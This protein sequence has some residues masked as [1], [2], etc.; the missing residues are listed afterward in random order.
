MR[1]RRVIRTLLVCVLLGAGAT[2]LSSWAIHAVRYMLAVP[3]PK[4]VPARGTVPSFTILSVPYIPWPVDFERAVELGMLTESPRGQM[5][6]DPQYIALYELG[7][8]Y[9]D[10]TVSESRLRDANVVWR[11]HRTVASGLPRTPNSPFPFVLFEHDASR[12]GWRVTASRATVSSIEDLASG[13]ITEETLNV[14]RAGWPLLA[15]ESGAHYAELIEKESYQ[16][17]FGDTHTRFVSHSVLARPPVVSLRGGLELW[18]K[19]TPP[20]ANRNRRQLADAFAAA[21]AETLFATIVGE[22]GSG[23]GG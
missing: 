15:L 13:H 16:D 22:A 2:V 6:I 10:V 3:G 19:T 17:S 11:R 12:R 7:G 1:F 9:P 18:R 8:L 5:V 23:S 4:F 20:N 14:I 21:L